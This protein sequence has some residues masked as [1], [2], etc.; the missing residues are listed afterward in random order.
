VKNGTQMP[1]IFYDFRGLWSCLS[2]IGE[3]WHADAADFL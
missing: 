1:L 3:E 2:L